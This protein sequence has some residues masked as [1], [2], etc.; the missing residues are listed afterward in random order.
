MLYSDIYEDLG[1]YDWDGGYPW[2]SI[3]IT[4]RSQILTK[5]VNLWVYL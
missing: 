2:I 5:I 3:A 1:D 4:M